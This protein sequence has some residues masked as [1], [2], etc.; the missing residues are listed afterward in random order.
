MEPQTHVADD[1]N[2]KQVEAKILDFN[3]VFIGDNTARL[4]K[5]LSETDNDEIFATSQIRVFVDFMWQGYYD[6]IFSQLFIPFI[7]YFASFILYTGYFSHHEEDELS[8]KFILEMVS[9][10]VFG[11]TFVTFLILEMIQIKNRGLSYFFDVWNLVD[12]FSLTLNM[13]YVF[14]EVMNAISHETLQI[15]ASFAIFLMWFKLFYWMR[16]FKPFSAFI[17]MITE[18]MKDIQ[19]FLVMLIISLGAFANIIFLLNLNRTDNGGCASTGDCAAIYDDL[20]GI[21]PIDSMIH[22]Y[23][24]GLG[25]FNKDN[26][27]SENSK[28]MWFMFILATIIVQLIFM[29]LLIAIMGESFSRITAI[30]QQSTLK[31]LCSIMED[32]IWLQ[33]IDEL[34]ESKRYILWLTPDTST[35]GGTVVERQITQLKDQVKNRTEQQEQRI[36]RAISLLSEDVA[37]IKSTMDEQQ[38]LKENEESD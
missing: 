30:M 1:S 9:L 32:H 28:T 22:A 12:I 8:M 7:L 20:V 34:F 13:I 25:D 37:A 33:K 38:K 21:A 11:K 24:T 29:N 6:A 14:G 5:T 4:I 18:I 3:W 36:L 26:Y 15:I 31:E 19:V 27:S 23:L 17:R 2:L 10:V 16:L 35:G